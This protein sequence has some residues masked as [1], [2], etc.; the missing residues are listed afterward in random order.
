MSA[1]KDIVFWMRRKGARKPARRDYEPELIRAWKEGAIEFNAGRYWEAHERWERGWKG[2]PAPERAWVQGW[3]QL[4]GV[5]VLLG[6]GRARPAQA[7]RMRALIKLN[8]AREISRVRPRL[9]IEGG[10]EF[11]RRP[12]RE[13]ERELKAAK[14]LKA[15]LLL[16]SRL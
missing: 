13:P 12:P 2:L 4:A 5:L 16:P 15:K 6:K 10:R 8:E 11:L 3:I 1:L 14:A 9:T 7:L